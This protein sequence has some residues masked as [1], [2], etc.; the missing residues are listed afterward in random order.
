MEYDNSAD[1]DVHFFVIGG[2]GAATRQI[3]AAPHSRLAK[4]VQAFAVLDG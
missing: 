2:G 4:S 3:T 1:A